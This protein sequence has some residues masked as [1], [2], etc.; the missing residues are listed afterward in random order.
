METDTLVTIRYQLLALLCLQPFFPLWECLGLP[1]DCLDG[2]ACERFLSYPVPVATPSLILI[3]IPILIPACNL[4]LV[5]CSGNPICARSSVYFSLF[6]SG[7][8]AGP[9]VHNLAFLCLCLCFFFVFAS[10]VVFVSVYLFGIAAFLFGEFRSVAEGCEFSG[11]TQ[12]QLAS[13]TYC[14]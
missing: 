5:T 4:Q 1:W 2:D 3:P 13:G 9:C 10:L 12:L 11:D 14:W 7:S 6:F 8:P